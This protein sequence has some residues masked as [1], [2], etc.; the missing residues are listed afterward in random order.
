MSRSG[1][2]KKT[3]GI[4]AENSIIFAESRS[5]RGTKKVDDEF[6]HN[7]PVRKIADQADTGS[8]DPT[9]IYLKELGFQTLLT[10]K[11]EVR[12]ARRIQKGDE[13]A[14]NEMIECNLRLVVKIARHYLNR[15]LAF[16][17]SYH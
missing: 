4:M 14:R 6:A 5:K 15:G 16:T 1:K 9:Q 7:E 17:Y 2:S 11:D 3:S 8:M 13:T 10:A 12:L